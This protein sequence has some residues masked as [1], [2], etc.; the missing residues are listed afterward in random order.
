M[1][2]KLIAS[3]YDHTL[4][5][6]NDTVSQ[7]NYEMIRTYVN[8]GGIFCINTGRELPS[9]LTV[10]QASPISD[11]DIVIS[12]HQGAMIYLPKTKQVLL[13]S[14]LKISDT[15]STMKYLDSVDN[16][17]SFVFCEDNIICKE[18]SPFLLSY[19]K[20]LKIST[21]IIVVDSYS[22]YLNK[23][24]DAPMK[25]NVCAK[26]EVLSKIIPEVNRQF[27]LKF[28][29]IGYDMAELVAP[30]TSK[31]EAHKFICNYFHI[32]IEETIGIGD[33]LNDMSLI[34]TAG[35]GI[36]VKNGCYELK[37]AAQMVVGKASLGAVGRIIKRV[38]ENKI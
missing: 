26:P 25:I 11:L 37:M 1:R 34:E 36:A 29:P 32:K 21:N 7:L 14:T 22:E 23:G 35:L 18:K 30:N 6:D 24:L 5:D 2:Y 16:L 15:I 8:K 4:T 17:E 31:G 20:V 19:V 9:I 3:D 38:M 33:S 27:H 13:K 10:F 12:S 28:T